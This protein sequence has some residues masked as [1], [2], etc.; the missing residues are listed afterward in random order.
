M[1]VSQLRQPDFLAIIIP[2]GLIFIAVSTVTYIV[3]RGEAVKMDKTTFLILLPIFNF[4]YNLKEMMQPSLFTAEDQLKI[5]LAK[6][7][8]EKKDLE[9]AKSTISDTSRIKKG[10]QNLELDK[11]TQALLKKSQKESGLLSK[12]KLLNPLALFKKEEEENEDEKLRRFQRARDVRKDTIGV[13]PIETLEEQEKKRKMKFQNEER[14]QRMQDLRDDYNNVQTLEGMENMAYK[15]RRD[16]NLQKT[17]IADIESDEREEKLAQVN[18]FK[19]QLESKQKAKEGAEWFKQFNTDVQKRRDR[20][21]DVKAQVLQEQFEEKIR[22]ER[23]SR[24]TMAFKQ[25]QLDLGLTTEETSDEDETSSSKNDAVFEEVIPEDVKILQAAMQRMEE[26]MR[27]QN[28][29]ENERNQLQTEMDNIQKRLTS[30]QGRLSASVS[31]SGTGTGTGTRFGTANDSRMRTGTGTRFGT[32]SGS[33]MTGTDPRMST[34]SCGTFQIHDN[35]RPGSEGLSINT[36]LS[37]WTIPTIT[38]AKNST[39]RLSWT[40]IAKT[41]IDNI[42]KLMKHREIY[43]SNILQNENIKR[44]IDMN[45]YMTKVENIQVNHYDD[46]D[47]DDMDGWGSGRH[48]PVSRLKSFLEAR[49]A[50]RQRLY[51][52]KTTKSRE[53]SIYEIEEK[54]H[55]TVKNE[56]KIN[57][58]ASL[59]DDDRYKKSHNLFLENQEQ[60][61]LQKYQQSCLQYDTKLQSIRIL[62]AQTEVDKRYQI[63]M[64]P[65][66]SAKTK[67]KDNIPKDDF[68]I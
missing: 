22:E 68:I 26:K 10:R 25:Q 27:Q 32:A 39:E 11:R 13:E 51:E 48:R 2:V 14:E 60:Q 15:R 28:D 57:Y 5:N 43:D 66:E 20:T 56:R 40:P 46:V 24:L 38:Q 12:L 4:Y 64:I 54:I 36:S 53:K 67:K 1:S 33:R 3:T 52:D 29:D 45:K 61:R 41:R 50:S 37:N 62:E 30:Y 21:I 35:F 65:C 42:G 55:K 18:A 8:K 23:G 58:L 34:G 49:L 9:E 44:Q 47:R 59:L 6:M 63:H 17:R 19:D 16:S 7:L 31:R